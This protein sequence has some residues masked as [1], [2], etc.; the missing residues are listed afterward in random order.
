MSF[1]WVVSQYARWCVGSSLPGPRIR[2]LS[3]SIVCL[4]VNFGCHI[5]EIVTLFE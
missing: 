3:P 1:V 5:E 2:R 4:G